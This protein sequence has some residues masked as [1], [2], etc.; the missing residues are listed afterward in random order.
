MKS[1]GL[2]IVFFAALIIECSANILQLLPIQVFSK[3]SLMLIL[4]IYFK[5]HSKNLPTLKNLIIAALIFSW[6]GD[7]ILLL[8]K[9]FH[10]LFIFGLISFLI[11]H[12]FYV[13]YFWKC[14][15]HNLHKTKTNP[16]IV[17]A[18]LLYTLTFYFLLFPYLSHL[19]FPV[20]VYCLIISLML[21]TSFLAFDFAQ[22]S[23]GKIS[24]IGTI[25]FVVSDSILG[26]NRFVS[27][28]LFGSVLVMITYSIGQLLIVEG[29]LRNLR[30]IDLK[31]KKTANV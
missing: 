14:R 31:Q 6:L 5:Y 23:F 16:I 22:Q 18:V 2:I 24:V 13:I 17:L 15:K 9:H 10:S 25:L 3:P 21:M 29:A 4:I 8:D 19:K 26:I 20:F 30:E 11:A 27:P 12:I 7:V 1:K 28:I